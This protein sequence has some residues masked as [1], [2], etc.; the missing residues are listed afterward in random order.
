MLLRSLAMLIVNALPSQSKKEYIRQ[1]ILEV[2]SQ[3]SK[4]N[5]RL[6][7]LQNYDHVCLLETSNSYDSWGRNNVT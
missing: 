3:V 5:E 1:K 6:W 4:E 2:I 7:C